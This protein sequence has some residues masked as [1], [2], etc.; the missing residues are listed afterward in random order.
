MGYA[1]FSE[2]NHPV[3]VGHGSPGLLF[4]IGIHR[5][6]ESGRL[7]E[8]W[9]MKESMANAK[10]HKETRV[11][12]FRNSIAKGRPGVHLWKLVEWRIGLIY[13]CSSA[14]IR[15]TLSSYREAA[16]ATAERSL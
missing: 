9:T 6:F 12:L 11:P 4:G 1:M 14:V 13:P 16:I 5:G 8:K 2:L 3:V 7:D 10:M 15:K